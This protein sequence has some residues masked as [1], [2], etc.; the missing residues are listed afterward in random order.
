MHIIIERPLSSSR[1]QWFLRISGR[2]EHLV[3]SLSESDSSLLLEQ[4]VEKSHA[5]SLH[6][7]EVNLA[8]W[9]PLTYREDGEQVRGDQ[10]SRELVHTLSHC[11]LRELCLRHWELSTHYGPSPGFAV[12]FEAFSRLSTLTNLELSWCQFCSITEWQ[13]DCLWAALASL[14]DLKVLKMCL[15]EEIEEACWVDDKCGARPFFFGGLSRL[16]QIRALSVR[17]FEVSLLS[18]S[19]FEDLYTLHPSFTALTQLKSLKFGGYCISRCFRPITALTQLEELWLDAHDSEYNFSEEEYGPPLDL[20][21]LCCLTSLRLHG[22]IWDLPIEEFLPVPMP[23]M[24]SICGS[25]EERYYQLTPQ[26]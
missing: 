4:F 12:E 7:L 21:P 18:T 19:I 11:D 25:D 6:R 26:N 3:V 17:Q 20:S 15:Q 2:V 5:L 10:L 22:C 1:L 9:A 14:S 8:P 24:A 16:T 23:A 13:A